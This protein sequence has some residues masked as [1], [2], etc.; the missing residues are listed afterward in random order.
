MPFLVENL[1]ALLRILVFRASPAELSASRNL[2]IL[3]IAGSVGIGYLAAGILPQPGPVELQLLAAMIVTLGLVYLALY[4]RGLL[5][6]FNQTASAVF[7]T[8]LLLSLPM[9]LIQLQVAAVDEA[10]AGLLLAALTLWVWRLAVL[11]HVFAEAMD[12]RRSLGVL[13]AVVYMIIVLQIVSAL[14]Q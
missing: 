5:P 13:A 8:D 12:V 14:A 7:G 9:L 4:W 1:R 3:L 10:G 6:R 2:L 11:G